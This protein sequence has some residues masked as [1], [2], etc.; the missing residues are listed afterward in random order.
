MPA[1]YKIKR[2]YKKVEVV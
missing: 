2:F 1:G